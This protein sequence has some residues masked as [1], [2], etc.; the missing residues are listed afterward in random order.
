MKKLLLICLIFL[1]CLVSTGCM[2]GIV[3]MTINSDSTVDIFSQVGISESGMAMINSMAK[4]EETTGMSKEEMTKF[5]YK[6]VNYYGEITNEKLNSIEELKSNIGEDTGVSVDTGMFDLVKNSDGTYTLTLE[7]T[8][9]TANTEE[10]ETNMEINGINHTTITQLMKDM[11]V[12][13]T[14]NMPDK[15]IQISGNSQGITING[16]K[17]VIDF[18]KLE[19]PTRENEKMI[20]EFTTKKENT[21][22]LEIISNQ[23][24]TDVPVDLWSYTAINKLAEGGLVSGVGEGR[25]SPERG[26]KIAEFCQVL[27]NAKGLESGSD[28]NGYWAAKAINSCINSGYIYSHGEIT[29]ENY[30]VTI[31]RE[32]AVAAMQ[33]ASGRLAIAGKNITIENIPDGQQIDEKYKDIVLQAYNSGI[34]TGVNEQLKFSPKNKLTRGQVCQL[35]YNVNWTTKLP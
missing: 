7:V 11:V 13:Y 2:A 10:I 31:T 20:Y 32:E 26:M 5:T 17:L 33:L 12:L 34:T 28:A 35:F 9:E 30:D 1:M 19:V 14:V 16:N 4:D 8:N 23:K 27:A 29:P 18:L 6:G 3:E 25:F 21:S 24:F 22:K 15:I